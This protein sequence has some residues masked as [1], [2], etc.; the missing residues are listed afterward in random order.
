MKR[1]LLVALLLCVSASA[2]MWPMPGPGST[3]VV[4]APTGATDDFNRAN[5]ALGSNWTKVT[6]T[7]NMA[8]VS[9]RGAGATAWGGDA[10]AIFTGTTFTS[11]QY[12]EA[13]L[14]PASGVAVEIGVRTSSAT[15]ITTCKVT[16]TATTCSG[17]YH[18]AGSFVGAGDSFTITSGDTV[19]LE[20]TG[21]SAVIKLNGT[22][23]TGKGFTCSASGG[24]PGFFS[25]DSAA[26]RSAVDD[27]AAGNI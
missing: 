3:P 14:Y 24:N 21:T 4:A 20:V 12:V 1:V 8:V 15:P 27:F 11:D 22:T 23:Q 6:G 19:R 7:G 2:Q 5:G 9:N 17:R 13:K 16:C 10:W 18:N 26:P 25:A